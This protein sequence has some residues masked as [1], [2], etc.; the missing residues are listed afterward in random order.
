MHMRNAGRLLTLVSLVFLGIALYRADYLFLPEVRSWGCLAFSLLLLVAGFLLSALTWMLTLAVSG[1]A[2]RWRACLAGTGLSIFGKYI[3]GKIWIIAGRAAYAS[4]DSGH[5]SS[6]VAMVSL[7]TQLLDLWS[8]C[9]LGVAALIALGSSLLLEVVI[10]AL[11]LVLSLVLFNGRLSRF[12]SRWIRR[13]NLVEALLGFRWKTGARVIPVFLLCWLCWGTGFYFM[14]KALQSGTPHWAL[15]MVFPLSA[16]MG[17]VAVIAPGGL[18][19]REGA[20]VGLLVLA[21]YHQKDAVTLALA[22]RLWF[23]AGECS[24]FVLGFAA[25]LLR[26]QAGSVA[27][28]AR[29]VGDQDVS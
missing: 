12:V 10:L 9:S 18:G 11:W 14:V 4:S 22:S 24:C 1:Y 23:L 29:S 3:P 8:A 26:G 19:V 7:R 2:T 5:P 13:P 6:M 25:N 27:A 17:I 16:A 15:S 20:L 21:G 28:P